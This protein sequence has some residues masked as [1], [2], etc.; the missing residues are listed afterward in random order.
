MEPVTLG[1][2]GLIALVVLIAFGV[3]LAFAITLVAVAGILMAT[4]AVSRG[5]S[6]S[7]SIILL[8]MLE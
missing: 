6:S 5:R 7:M 3:P 2:I 1:V 8:V 4:I